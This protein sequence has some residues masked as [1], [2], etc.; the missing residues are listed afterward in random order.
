MKMLT[1]QGISKIP[2]FCWWEDKESLGVT[3]KATIYVIRQSSILL[4]GK[5]GA[6]IIMPIQLVQSG[7][8]WVH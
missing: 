8:P 4:K 5:G 2:L 6:L 7:L 3:A 1:L